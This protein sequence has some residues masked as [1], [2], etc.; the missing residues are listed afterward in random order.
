MFLGAFQECGFRSLRPAILDELGSLAYGITY[1]AVLEHLPGKE[2]LVIGLLDEDM[3]T[4][5]QLLRLATRWKRQQAEADSSEVLPG[6][7]SRTTA[8][9]ETA[10]AAFTL[11]SRFTDEIVAGF[12]DVRP[13]SVARLDARGREWFFT[14]AAKQETG[15]A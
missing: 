7:K 6:S 10:I 12:L 13:S 2:R 3:R 4:F 14:E 8:S 5:K 1:A 9:L 11:C 15:T